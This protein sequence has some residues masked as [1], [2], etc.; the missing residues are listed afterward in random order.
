MEARVSAGQ[1]DERRKTCP[2][3][4]AM[5]TAVECESRTPR[6]VSRVGAP[7]PPVVL[8]S[9]WLCGGCGCSEARAAA[10]SS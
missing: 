4:G 7:V 2:Q 6:Y 10:F 5:M 3:C 8:R 1:Q 9:W